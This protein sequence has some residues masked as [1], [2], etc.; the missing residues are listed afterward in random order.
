MSLNI[1]SHDEKRLVLNRLQILPVRLP[2][3]HS[4]FSGR[5]RSQHPHLL[6]QQH[7]DQWPRP[8]HSADHAGASSSWMLQGRVDEG[9]A[10]AAVSERDTVTNQPSDQVQ[11]VDQ[12]LGKVYITGASPTLNF[13]GLRAKKNSRNVSITMATPY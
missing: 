3:F 5:K 11:R 12:L 10:W 9:H 6:Y 1:L 13:S 2:P 7:V 8:V 4:S